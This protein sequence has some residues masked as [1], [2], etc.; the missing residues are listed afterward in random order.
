MN[1][2]KEMFGE[3][4]KD[5]TIKFIEDVND[6]VENYENKS[7][8]NVDWEKKY[9]ENDETWRKRYRDRFFNT[10]AEPEN[11]E[12]DIDPEDE[13]TQSKLTYENL[14]KEETK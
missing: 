9:K 1:K 7:K 10:P 3:D 13:T 11:R 6:T 4:T 2:I 12:P 8:D 5:E 14:F